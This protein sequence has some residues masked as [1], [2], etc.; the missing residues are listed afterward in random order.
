MIIWLNNGLQQSMYEP[1]VVFSCFAW[2]RI[3]AVEIYTICL[4]E[5]N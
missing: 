4:I 3:N 5:N 2:Y 1:K